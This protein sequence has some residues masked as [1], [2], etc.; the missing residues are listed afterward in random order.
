MA[1]TAASSTPRSVPSLLPGAERLDELQ[2][3]PG[4]LVEEHEAAGRSMRGAAGA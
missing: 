1:V 4:H 3:A 2:V